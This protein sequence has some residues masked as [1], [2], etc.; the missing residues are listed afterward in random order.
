MAA[1]FNRKSYGADITETISI[2]NYE[3]ISLE[4]TLIDMTDSL[5]K[6]QSN[7]LFTNLCL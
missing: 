4:K 5:K 1:I 6:S 3:P 7:E 2:Y